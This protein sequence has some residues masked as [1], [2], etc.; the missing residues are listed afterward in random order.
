MAI[1]KLDKIIVVAALTLIIMIAGF[2]AKPKPA[3]AIVP[4]L[5]WPAA[6]VAEEVIKYGTAVAIVLWGAN[7][8]YDLQ[9][10]IRDGEDE[11]DE[12]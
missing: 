10:K 7:E 6:I 3:H 4:L 11:K 12:E 8:A 5:L 9:D 2:F 1:K